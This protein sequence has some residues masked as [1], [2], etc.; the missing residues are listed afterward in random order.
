MEPDPHRFPESNEISLSRRRALARSA[1]GWATILLGPTS[2]GAASDDDARPTRLQTENSSS[3]VPARGHARIIAPAGAHQNVRPSPLK[4]NDWNYVL[5]GA[6]GS[7]DFNPHY[8]GHGAYILACSGGHSHPTFFG[9][10]VFDFTTK[11]WSYLPC[12]NAG[13]ASDAGGPVPGINESGSA[14]Y[15]P[16]EPCWASSG[17]PYWELLCVT[18]GQVP[19]P[20]HPYSS[21]VVLAPAHGGSAK[22]SML[23][24]GRAAC[25]AIGGAYSGT[26]HA[27]DL[28]TRKW[29]RKSGESIGWATGDGDVV[30]DPITIRYYS[31]IGN[32]HTANYLKYW[33]PV[34]GEW[35][36]GPLHRTY[37]N[38]SGYPGSVSAFIHEG[39]GLR[40]LIQCRRDSTSSTQDNWHLLS[41]IDLD[42]QTPGWI[43]RLNL[44]G[45][46]IPNSNA[47]WVYHPVQNVY[48]RRERKNMGQKLWRLTPPAGNAL[49]GTWTHDSVTLQ[50]DA[51]PELASVQYADY[52]GYRSLMYISA[53]Q[54]LGWVTPSGVALLNP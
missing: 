2:A 30:F 42:N 50:G 3:E 24:V 25:N 17:K 37:I 22:G 14:P 11:S 7:G 35:A 19:S 48:Y 10:A 8:S 27:F 36:N 46:R 53:L 23:Y 33:N 21:Q 41:G 16:A 40:A 12:T 29:S 20:P 49:T 44:A 9:A 47:K 54:M 51:V 45:E 6:F 52:S 5:F 34:N 26:V 32:L 1:A 15:N 39:S 28:V 43:R 38:D 13:L 31:I 18:E 4:A